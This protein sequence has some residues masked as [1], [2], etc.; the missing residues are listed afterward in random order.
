MN[1]TVTVIIPVRELSEYLFQSVQV[2]LANTPADVRIIVLTD[3]EVERPH[4]WDESRVQVMATGPVGPGAKRDFGVRACGTSIVAFLDDD[5]YPS[6]GWI[7]C[8]LPHF[9]DFDVAGVGG[10]N[11]T[12]AS[13]SFWQ[14]VSGLVY[15]TWMG[16]GGARIRYVPSG[17]SRYVNDWPSVNLLVRRS[18]FIVAGGFATNV[19]PGEDTKLCIALTV[20][21]GKHIIYEPSAIVFH[22]RRSLFWGHFRQLGNYARTRGRFSVLL[23]VTSDRWMYKIPSVLVIGTVASLALGF[24]VGQLEFVLLVA[25]LV[26]L[27]IIAIS[28][29]EAFIVSG[30]IGL[31]LAASTAILASHWWY[32]IQFIRGVVSVLIRPLTITDTNL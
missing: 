15:S 8:A 6:S 26:N 25:I 29:V 4:V 27:S 32:G 10:P 14:Q 19:F 3:Y 12:P 31:S 16:A 20:G 2:T 23:P 5:A 17:V 9:R 7:E 21:I 13:D 22:H 18:Y 11:V 1:D 28:C 30:Q 24:S